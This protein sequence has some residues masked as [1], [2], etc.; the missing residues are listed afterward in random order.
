MKTN[1]SRMTETISF[2]HNNPNY[3]QVR[4]QAVAQFCRQTFPK[5]SLFE[6]G[7][8]KNEFHTISDSMSVKKHVTVAP[9]T[10]DERKKRR[11][12]F[13]LWKALDKIQTGGCLMATPRA[14]AAM[15]MPTA[16]L[17]AALDD[18]MLKASVC[19]SPAAAADVFNTLV[20]HNTRQFLATHKVIVAGTPTGED[21]FINPPA[22]APDFTNVLTFHF[23][24]DAPNDRFMFNGGLM[25]GYGASHPFPTVSVPAVAW[26]DVQGNGGMNTP[27]AAGASF[28]QIYGC[29]LAGAPLMV[30][31]QFTG[32]AFCWTHHN[33]VTRAA[34]IAPTRAGRPSAALATSFPGGGL[35][36][37]QE[38]VNQLPPQLPGGGVAAGMANAPG[39][40]LNVIGCG[41]GQA[42]AIPAGNPFYPNNNLAHATIIGRL[43]NNWKFYLQA[44]DATNQIVEARRI[45]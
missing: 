39:A 10:Q 34:H 24:Y 15:T 20:L 14:D 36:L 30:T 5:L 22:I 7:A 11:A 1:Q 44:I 6:F 4:R 8:Y 35:G 25:P 18:A 17:D 23:Q 37:A 27:Q 32:C 12:I 42:P 40:T 26:Y 9:G 43:G 3:P 38:I 2:I 45:L 31:T 33:G 21:K 28:S 13:L 41:A 29:E 16:N 19:A